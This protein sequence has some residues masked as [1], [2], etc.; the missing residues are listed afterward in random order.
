MKKEKAE[1]LLNR[2]TDEE[3]RQDWLQYLRE[4][5]SGYDDDIKGYAHRTAYQYVNVI[6]IP[7]KTDK[8]KGF[9]ANCGRVVVLP[10]KL[11]HN[12]SCVCP[13][14]GAAGKVVHA[15]RKSLVERKGYFLYFQKADYDTGNVVCRGIYF[16]MTFDTESCKE[17]MHLEDHS[18]I[19]F[20]P[21]GVDHRSVFLDF[22]STRV[23]RKHKS[24]FSRF[25]NYA[26]HTGYF[27][28]N[29]RGHIVD[30]SFAS[31]TKAINGTFLQYSMPLALSD[32]SGYIVK[33]LELFIRY[34]KIELLVKNGLTY[35]L[36]EK[37]I[38][39]QKMP[40]NWRGQNM[41]DFLRLP[42]L[43]RKQKQYIRKISGVVSSNWLK[44]MQAYLKESPTGNLSL[45]PDEQLIRRLY[46]G[47]DHATNRTLRINELGVPILKIFSKVEEYHK[48]EHES[49]TGVLI[50][51]CDYLSM[52][53]RLEL[54]LK[55]TA[56]L[57]PKNL[58]RAHDNLA[59]QI[60]IYKDKLLEKQI[61]LAKERRKYLCYEN[62]EYFCRPA[63]ST[64]ELIAEGRT[65]HHCVATYAEQY[66]SYKT[67][68]VFIRRKSAPDTPFVTMEIGLDNHVIQARAEHNHIPDDDV[69][70]FIAEFKANILNKN[71]KARKAA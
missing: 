12:S 42:N 5:P 50:T 69:K 62:E 37:I 13:H 51:W 36:W 66:A 59:R 11:R 46:S 45:L 16:N 61:E 63:A 53:E 64:D 34:P 47:D 38:K 55:N 40:V 29:G 21:H 22:Y 60:K 70:K 6:A 57:F 2:M 35:L 27:V 39:G 15:W 41:S 7:S 17:Y 67:H 9:C 25:A 1:M 56:I 8:Q 52:A 14:C 20:T 65:L 4:I 23:Y 31:L 33:Y 3:E 54:D 44:I 30:V 19:L 28:F 43:G 68:I 71:K 58:H 49:Y 24:A 48:L 32:L 18:S 26:N 10:D